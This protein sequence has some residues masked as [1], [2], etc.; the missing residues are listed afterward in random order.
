V[1]SKYV[2]TVPDG[3][4]PSEAFDWVGTRLVHPMPQLPPMSP[5]FPEV[6]R[7]LDRIRFG[8]ER[9]DTDENDPRVGEFTWWAREY[10]RCYRYHLTCAEFR[11]RTI[12]ALMSEIHTELADRVVASPSVFEVGVG[13]ERVSR[14][15]WDFESYLSEVNNALDLL[16]RIAGLIYRRQTPPNFNRFCKI[17]EDSAMLRIMQGA[18]S[19]W[20]VKLKSY[21][22]CFTHFTPVDTMLSIRLVQYRDGFHI[23]AKLP[24]NPDVRE[25]LGFR[26]MRRVEL[27]RYAS[28]VW[29]HM[30]ALDRAV[31]RQIALDYADGVYPKRTTGLFFVS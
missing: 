30:A 12:H 31:A 21:R 28:T 7:V 6:V 20:V 3:R 13:D 19:R 8:L 18:Q 1:A 26:Y 5:H 17:R 14:V 27:L 9:G 4:Q 29:R 2:M 11:L 24:A 22:D 15:Y 25:I 16:A 10:P 23:R